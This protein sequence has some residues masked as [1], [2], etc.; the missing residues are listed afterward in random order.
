M[1]T[2]SQSM[3]LVHVVSGDTSSDS[4]SRQTLLILIDIPTGCFWCEQSFLTKLDC[5]NTTETLPSF[6]ECATVLQSIGIRVRC[7]QLLIE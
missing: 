7:T 2:T 3:L 6:W 1:T 4:G 5:M